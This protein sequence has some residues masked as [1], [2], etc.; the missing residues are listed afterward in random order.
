MAAGV[1]LGLNVP[2]APLAEPGGQRGRRW[3][4][5]VFQPAYLVA[6][7]GAATG[8]GIMFLAV[9]APPL[10]WSSITMRWAVKQL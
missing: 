7:L 4:E 1:P 8:Y 6:L 5:A 10:R 2:P 3:Q 9:T